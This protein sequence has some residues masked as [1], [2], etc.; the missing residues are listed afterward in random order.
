MSTTENSDDGTTTS[1]AEKLDS[2]ELTEA[3]TNDYSD[4]FVP[5]RE[6]VVNDDRIARYECPYCEYEDND[7]KILRTHITRSDDFRH[8]DRH[9]WS[10]ETNVIAYDTDGEEIGILP[11][12][13]TDAV[14]HADEGEMTTELVPNGVA[15][16]T[17][18]KTV[19]LTAMLNQ[20]DSISDIHEKTNAKLADEGESV[21][22]AYVQNIINGMNTASER[23]DA[24]KGNGMGRTPN[25]EYYDLSDSIRAALDQLVRYRHDQ[26]TTQRE[27]MEEIGRDQSTASYVKRKYPDLLEQRKQEADDGEVD[28]LDALVNNPEGLQEHPD[29]YDA[30][31]NIPQAAEQSQT[32]TAASPGSDADLHGKYQRL[33]EKTRIAID[34]LVIYYDALEDHTSIVSKNGLAS[35]LNMSPATLYYAENNYPEIFRARRAAYEHGT[36]DA[37]GNLLDS[38]ITPDELPYQ[39]AVERYD[40]PA[41]GEPT[42]LGTTTTATDSGEDTAAT[43]GGTTTQTTSQPGQ[44]AAPQIDTDRVLSHIDQRIEMLERE[45]DLTGSGDTVRAIVELESVQSLLLEDGAEETTTDE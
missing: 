42:S 9:G 33:G 2:D 23:D 10:P 5:D 29:Y 11:G 7:E 43:D 37:P 34:A 14:T 15:S 41:E 28:I 31:T 39:F 38:E 17:K 18:K 45:A 22:Y 16:G 3:F 26:Q 6:F 27:M 12:T 44:A 19:I 30:E 40:P 36:L 8:E 32:E 25:T 1:I 24:R 21:S 4:Q 13:L 35:D 20:T